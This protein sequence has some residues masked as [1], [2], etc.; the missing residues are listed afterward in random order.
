MGW[1]AAEHRAGTTKCAD[2]RVSQG[3]RP[4]FTQDCL[5]LFFFSKQMNLNTV[6]LDLLHVHAAHRCFVS[7]RSIWS[8]WLTAHDPFC[9]ILSLCPPP[10]QN[11][12]CWINITFFIDCFVLDI[13]MQTLQ[14]A[15]KH[16]RS[17][18]TAQRK[19]LAVLF[20][21]GSHAFTI[22]IITI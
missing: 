19:D 9:C 1:R 4:I 12:T 13:K 11:T 14:G 8:V 22:T 7:K 18:R 21:F 10:A 15:V 5:R 17:K 2:W 20:P 3:C 6:Q 16:L